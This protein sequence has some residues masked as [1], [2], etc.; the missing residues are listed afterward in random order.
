MIDIC[1]RFKCIANPILS[2]VTTVLLALSVS[3][4][5]LA[6]TPLSTGVTTK[7]A[8][9]FPANTT[10]EEKRELSTPESV[11][12]KSIYKNTSEEPVSQ[13]EIRKAK[14]SLTSLDL[15]YPQ[16]VL[17]A[18]ISQIRRGESPP[19]SNCQPYSRYFGKGC[20]PWCADFVSWAIDSVDRNKVVPWGNPSTAT[21]IYN[22]ASKTGRFVRTPRP[23]DIFIIKGQHTGF[24]KLAS[25]GTFTTVEGNTGNKVKSLR[26]S[27]K[28]RYFFVRYSP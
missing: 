8:R 28:D 3:N 22:W 20:Q 14:E 4:P 15:T 25:G 1:L 9:Q 17:N 19:R 10:A 18:A 27:F 26:R 23:G 13:E 21:S 11:L 7:I 16:K 2:F 6:Q 5:V 12:Q 24:V